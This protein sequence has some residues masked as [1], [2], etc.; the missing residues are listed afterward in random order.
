MKGLKP[1]DT[2][3]IFRN[4]VT[5]RPWNCRHDR[6]RNHPGRSIG[7]PLDHRSV[8][9]M[10]RGDLFR[11]DGGAMSRVLLALAVLAALATAPEI[12]ELLLRVAIP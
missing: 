9:S 10:K 1:W 11:P 3:I 8:E 6:L 7:R 12:A 5:S 2:R 4:N